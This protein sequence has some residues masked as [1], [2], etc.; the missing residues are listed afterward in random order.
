MSI[1]VSTQTKTSFQVSAE[2]TGVLSQTPCIL[3]GQAR[4]GHA[5]TNSC[6][7]DPHN[8]GEGV[9]HLNVKEVT[10]FIGS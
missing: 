7:P 1:Y 9:F 4:S 3:Y 8:L 5:E 6:G 10:V 2:T